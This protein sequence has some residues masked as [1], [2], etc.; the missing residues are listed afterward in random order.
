MD[1]NTKISRNPNRLYSRLDDEIVM[2]DLDTG[3]YYRLNETGT[4]IWDF[5]KKAGIS[6]GEIATRISKEFEVDR[7]TSLKDLVYFMKTIEN[8]K[9]FTTE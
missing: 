1:E 2:I 8:K 3:K 5:A 6:L 4:R 7:A 9:V